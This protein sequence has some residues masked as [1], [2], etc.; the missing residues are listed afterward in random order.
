[1]CSSDLLWPSR[2]QIWICPARTRRVFPWRC[3][4]LARTLLHWAWSF[5]LGLPSRRAS[6]AQ[7]SSLCTVPGTVLKRTV[8]P[9]AKAFS[10]KPTVWPS[11]IQTLSNVYSHV[12]SSRN[13]HC[14]IRKKGY[15]CLARVYT[16]SSSFRMLLF[17]ILLKILMKNVIFWILSGQTVRKLRVARTIEDCFTIQ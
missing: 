11:N 6:T 17:W 13:I 8:C 16:K 2:T 1:M 14:S 5:T 4:P 12:E 3:R 15:S 7:S 9:P 10:E